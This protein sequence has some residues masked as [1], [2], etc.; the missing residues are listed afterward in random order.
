MQRS[1]CRTTLALLGLLAC[2]LPAFAEPVVPD[3]NG[4]PPV[5][6][7][8]GL[9]FTIK[10]QHII[11]TDQKTGKRR[12]TFGK[13]IGLGTWA[14]PVDG[15]IVHGGLL[16]YARP[17][18][19]TFSE[20]GWLYALDARTGKR[21]WAVQHKIPLLSIGS[22]KS[23]GIYG[24]EASNGMMFI[25]YDSDLKNEDG[26]FTI[27][28]Y[29][30]KTGE[31][32]WRTRDFDHINFDHIHSPAKIEKNILLVT[33]NADNFRVHEATIAFDRHTGE[34]LWYN[35][36]RAVKVRGNKVDMVIHEFGVDPP[37]VGVIDMTVD[38]KTGKTLSQTVK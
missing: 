29:K 20:N 17:R 13:N 12:W 35:F 26:E 32:L 21:L 2:V 28:A 4:K 34:Y 14:S 1:A 5:V 22:N 11:A 8:E 38:A 10:N 36:G 15:R 19:Y 37:H 25:T 9:A 30:A 23:Y 16:L 27:A 33:C 7:G 6:I 3:E 31:E 24:M 18:L